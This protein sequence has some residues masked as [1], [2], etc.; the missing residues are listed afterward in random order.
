MYFSKW[1]HVSCHLYNEALNYFKHIDKEQTKHTTNYW[2]WALLLSRFWGV[3]KCD[4]KICISLPDVFCWQW[5]TVAYVRHS[6]MR[7]L[8]ILL[9][10]QPARNSTVVR[11]WKYRRTW[12]HKITWESPSRF[13]TR[14]VLSNIIMAG[15]RI[16]YTLL[17]DFGSNR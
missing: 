9:A 14:K 15:K 10:Q 7:L 3:W 13:P 6:K 8:R 2:C 11:N 16:M 5:V 17:F 12:E 1:C 4:N